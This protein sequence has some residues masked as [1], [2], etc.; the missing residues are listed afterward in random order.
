MALSALGPA[1]QPL[2]PLFGCSLRASARTPHHHHPAAAAALVA[3]GSR[4]FH[5][6]QPTLFGPPFRRSQQSVHPVYFSESFSAEDADVDPSADERSP[7]VAA[8]PPPSTPPPPPSSPFSF[9]P[10][11][12]LPLSFLMP[13]N[14]TATSQSV[15]YPDPKVAVP[16][17]EDG[18]HDYTR[19]LQG[20]LAANTHTAS[21]PAG[22]P[23]LDLHPAIPPMTTPGLVGFAVG[24]PSITNFPMSPTT[25]AARIAAVDPASIAMAVDTSIVVGEHGRALVSTPDILTRDIVRPRAMSLGGDEDNLPPGAPSPSAFVRGGAV[26]SHIANDEELAASEAAAAAAVAS[27][28]AIPDTDDMAGIET[29]PSG[30][31]RNT[32]GFIKLQSKDTELSRDL[33]EIFLYNQRWAQQTKHRDPNYFRKLASQQSPKFLWIGC[34]D[35]RVP[36]NQL[37]GLAPGEVFVHRNIANVVVHTDLNCLSVLQY[38]VSVLR[39]EHIIVCGHYRCGG[40][41]AAMTRSSHGLIDNWLRSIKDVCYAN[42]A[43]LSAIKDFERRADRAC[44]L[45]VREQV[46]N[47]CQTEIVQSA[48]ARGQS[49]S[50]HGWIYDI[51]DGLLRDL[52]VCVTSAEQLSSIYRFDQDTLSK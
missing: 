21:I 27:A 8:A 44:E 26:F 38:A 25:T 40:V 28:A 31:D 52:A 34:S 17:P 22:M 9:I 14:S 3:A 19:V 23:R 10:Q 24:Q 15:T 37:M 11:L 43:E 51:S 29:H 6:S 5:T 1:L 13:S 42:Q 20:A 50:V 7:P 4:F 12:L 41:R 47:I 18:E 32:S 39:V 33:S 2:A 36:A 35:S 16:A 48:W 45:N 30:L 46:G 49:L